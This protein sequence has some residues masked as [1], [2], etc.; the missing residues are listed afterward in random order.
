MES[1]GC[2]GYH[3]RMT[4]AATQPQKSSKV[5]AAPKNM[6]DFFEPLRG[7]EM[8]LADD[9]SFRDRRMDQLAETFADWED[10]ASGS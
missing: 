8:T 2:L 3:P 5:I 4:Q 7:T 6:L 1:Q 9:R 10:E